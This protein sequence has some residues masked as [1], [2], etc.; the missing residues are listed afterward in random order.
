MTKGKQLLVSLGL[1]VHEDKILLAQRKG[2]PDK[3]ELPGGKVENKES[4]SQAVIREVREE[5]GYVVEVINKIPFSY[6]IT[7]NDYLKITLLCF[8]CKLMGGELRKERNE[9]DDVQW[10]NRNELPNIRHGSRDF[11]SFTHYSIMK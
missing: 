7:A 6:L 1:I 11:I 5:T 10:F 2:V 3:W 8:E 9:V 4:P